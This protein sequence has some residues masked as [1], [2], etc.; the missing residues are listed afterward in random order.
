[1]NLYVRVWLTP[2]YSDYMRILKNF[3][4][5]RGIEGVAFTSVFPSV[6]FWKLRK[7]LKNP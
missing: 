6:L 1:M 2:N 7:L 4:L 5:T 3:P